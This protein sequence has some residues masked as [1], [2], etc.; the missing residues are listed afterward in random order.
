MTEVRITHIG[1]KSA[2]GYRSTP[3]SCIS[4]GCASP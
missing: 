4:E 3:R 1:A 2:T